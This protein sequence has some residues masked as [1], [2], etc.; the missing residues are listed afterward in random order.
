MSNFFSKVR[1]VVL[2][3]V[4]C[5]VRRPSGLLGDG[6]RTVPPRAA[7]VFHR[8][9]GPRMG[10]PPSFRSLQNK[11]DTL[12]SAPSPGQ[13]VVSVLIRHFGLGLPLTGLPQRVVPA[14]PS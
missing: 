12:A 5:F 11:K 7:N 3:C 6:A 8:L 10:G 13:S 9:G 1:R 14:A 4:R 2:P